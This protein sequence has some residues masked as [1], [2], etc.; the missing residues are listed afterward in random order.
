MGF[1]TWYGE[2]HPKLDYASAKSNKI[3]KQKQPHEQNW[4][5]NQDE[6]TKKK[7]KKVV[8]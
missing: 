4:K 5:R 3:P 6:Q 1:F 7:K 2:L 8:Q